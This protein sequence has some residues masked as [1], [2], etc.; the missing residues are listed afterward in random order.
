MVFFQMETPLVDLRQMVNSIDM[1]AL[2]SGLFL[3]PKLSDFGFHSWPVD[4]NREHRRSPLSWWFLAVCSIAA[5]IVFSRSRSFDRISDAC[6][7][8]LWLFFSLPRTNPKACRATWFSQQSPFLRSAA[9]SFFVDGGLSDPASWSSHVLKG[10]LIVNWFGGIF[11]SFCHD[12][13]SLTGSLG[14]RPPLLLLWSQFGEVQLHCLPR[15]CHQASHSPLDITAKKPLHK[16]PVRPFLRKSSGLIPMCL[17]CSML[18][19]GLQ[20]VA[21]HLWIS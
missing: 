3:N 5:T 12:L 9:F 15:S 6:Q 7:V 11:S 1:E 14:C 19:P 21:E 16:D 10:T 2:T 8:R 20:R 18:D 13:P 17:E 4:P